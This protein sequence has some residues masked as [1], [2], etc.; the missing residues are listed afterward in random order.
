M[1]SSTTSK[2]A[3]SP[4]AVPAHTQTG[5]VESDKCDKTRTVVV[6][7]MLKHPKYGKYVRRKTV[8]YVHDEANES[9]L[10]DTVE[11]TP[12]RPRSATKRYSLVRVLKRGTGALLHN[13]DQQGR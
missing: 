6:R 4:D 5:V 2:A 13:E 12:C 11:V 1:P 3:K 8:L 9:K 7:W 10:G